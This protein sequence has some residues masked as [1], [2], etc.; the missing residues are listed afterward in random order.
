MER[1]AVAGAAL[2]A[3]AREPPDIVVELSMRRDLV[4]AVSALQRHEIDLAF[5]NVAALAGSLPH[6]LTAELVMTDTIAALVSAHSPLAEQYPRS[7]GAT[8]VAEGVNLG[9][10]AFVHHVAGDP[11]LI[12]P[13]HLAAGRPHGRPRPAAPPRPALPLV[14]RPADRQHPPIPAARPARPAGSARTSR[15]GS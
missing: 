2:R 9:L 5:G 10:D 12:A 1:P 7:T 8:L 13:V 4:E 11:G 15:T 14:R 3:I 6:E